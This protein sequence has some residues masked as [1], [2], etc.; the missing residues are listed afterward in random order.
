[1]KALKII[2]LVSLLVTGA[3]SAFSQSI[4][5]FLPVITPPSP[6]AAGLC[7]F[8]N[9]EINLFTGVPQIS[10]PLYAIKV[11]ELNVP[12]TLD[13]H[14][15]GIKVNDIASRAGLGWSLNAGG[16]ISRKIMGKPDEQPSNYFS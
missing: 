5:K 14:A 1:M 11:G 4:N 2:L 6:E 15:S 8:G 10:I 7:R 13:Y 16:V 9:Y 12:I 3:D